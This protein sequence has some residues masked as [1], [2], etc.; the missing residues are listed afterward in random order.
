MKYI[1]V[2]TGFIIICV[3]EVI[4]ITLNYLGIIR[5]P[6]DPNLWWAFTG[7]VIGSTALIIVLIKETKKILKRRRQMSDKEFFKRIGAIFILIQQCL[8][9]NYK[10]SRCYDVNLPFINH[11]GR[12]G[13]FL[14]NSL[15]T[16]IVFTG[17]GGTQLEHF[18]TAYLKEDEKFS[19]LTIR[20]NKDEPN[21]EIAEKI[22][23][24]LRG[25]FTQITIL[26]ILAPYTRLVTY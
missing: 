26:E 19:E 16:T 12:Y 24:Q 8:P 18:G 23:R 14:Q 10:L 15:I 25:Y 20:Y 3:I 17:V 13:I 2:V 22:A 9:P 7:L 4:L 11:K 6:F 21:R 5:E 1:C